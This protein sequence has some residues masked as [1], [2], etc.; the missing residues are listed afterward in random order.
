MASFFFWV[1]TSEGLSPL[2]SISASGFFL[3]VLRVVFRLVVE[4]AEDALFL[5]AFL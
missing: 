5:G 4:T 3:V 1:A 2:G